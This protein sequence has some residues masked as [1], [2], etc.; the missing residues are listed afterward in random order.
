MVQLILFGAM[1]TRSIIMKKMDR[2]EADEI[3]IFLSRDKGWLT[4]VA[5]NSRKSRVRF[6]GH[7]EPFCLVDIVIR[8]RRKD[9]MVWIDEA[10]MV[11]G[12]LRIRENMELLARASYFLELSSGLL[13]E[14]Q[15]DSNVFDLLEKI[16]ESLDKSAPGSIEFLVQ[17]IRLLAL[18]GYQPAFDNCPLCGKGFSA[19]NDTIFSPWAGGLC[20]KTCLNEPSPINVPVS[21]ATVVA[22]CHALNSDSRLAG[23]IKLSRSAR[24][25]IRRSLSAFVRYVRGQ[26]LKSLKFMEDVGYF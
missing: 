24:T 1:T 2:G 11:K 13:P 15:A 12:F 18:L 16:L 3:V 23:R 17:E 26:D 9:A 6:G 21:P 22:L 5:K 8:S 14:G 25:E 10:H 20:H 4:G 19:S 7:L